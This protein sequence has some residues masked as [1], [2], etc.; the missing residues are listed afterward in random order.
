LYVGPSEEKK[1]EDVESWNF[2]AAKAT[3]ELQGK[4]A[5]DDGGRKV[6]FSGF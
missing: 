3:G 1:K 2:E 5:P 6:P 4:A